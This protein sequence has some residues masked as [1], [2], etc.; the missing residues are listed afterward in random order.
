MLGVISIITKM[1]GGNKASTKK[2]KKYALIKKCYE[3]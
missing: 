2:E 3:S 1:Q